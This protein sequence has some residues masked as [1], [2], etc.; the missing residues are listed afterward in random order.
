M[1]EIWQIL[2]LICSNLHVEC[3][4]RLA[5]KDLE[6]QALL[7]EL[8]EKA[9]QVEENQQQQQ[10]T[11]LPKAFN[12]SDSRHHFL[13][14]KKCTHIYT[15]SQIA[16][17]PHPWFSSDPLLVPGPKRAPTLKTQII[18]SGPVLTHTL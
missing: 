7:K 12:P 6:L 18:W 5:D 8:E 13:D 4:F 17:V 9:K 16:S 2:S 1:Y 11:K 15:F 3:V 14:Y 10:V